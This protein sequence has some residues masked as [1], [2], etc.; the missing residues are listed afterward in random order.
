MQEEIINEEINLECEPIIKMNFS[1]KVLHR[2]EKIYEA[3]RNA[4]FIFYQNL[5]K[6]KQLVA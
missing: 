2:P 5:I 3:E 6:L 1:D 4:K